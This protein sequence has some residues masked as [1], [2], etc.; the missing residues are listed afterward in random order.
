MVTACVKVWTMVSDWKWGQRWSLQ[1]PRYGQWS[2]TGS[3]DN[4]GHCM[5]QGMDNGQSL[6]VGTTMVTACIKVWTMVSHWKWDYDGH[7]MYQGMDNGQSLE[8]GTTMVTAWIGSRYGQWSVTG[9]GDNDGHCMDWIKVWTMVSHW[10]WGQRWSLHGLDQGMDNGQSLEVETMMVTAC[11][12]V[13]TM[14]S[15]WKWG[16]R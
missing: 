16:Q 2:V 7:C 3:G 15:H 13:W 9:S 12:K 14:V 4:D 11:V 8:V 6:E 10:K 5:Y 1:V